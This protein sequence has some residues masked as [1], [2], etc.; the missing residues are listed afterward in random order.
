MLG[1]NVLIL[2]C[3]LRQIVVA[4]FVAGLVPILFRVPSDRV[5]CMMQVCGVCGV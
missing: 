2:A 5:K 4:G 1:S 3:R